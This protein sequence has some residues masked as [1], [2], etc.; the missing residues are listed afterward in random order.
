VAFVS[1]NCRNCIASIAASLRHAANITD[2]LPAVQPEL[3]PFRLRDVSAGNDSSLP[4]E[5]IQRDARTTNVHLYQHPFVHEEL[6]RYAK[7]RA[8]YLL[9]S[10]CGVGAHDHPVPFKAPPAP[11]R[12]WR[13]F[14][15][16]KDEFGR[17]TVVRPQQLD[18]PVKFHYLGTA[19]AT[20]M[21]YIAL[22]LTF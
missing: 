19:G 21:H 13:N 12:Y 5:S 4:V 16:V 1:R 14:L 11:P 22:K 2:L 18:L 17:L 10:I 3:E 7:Q 8:G 20:G 15:V 9:H 6:Q